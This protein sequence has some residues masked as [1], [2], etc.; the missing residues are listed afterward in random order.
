[1]NKILFQRFVVSPL[2]LLLV[3]F[4]TTS[5]ISAQE[6]EEKIK[7]S[8]DSKM[9]RDY[10]LRMLDEMKSILKENYYDSKMRGIDLESRIDAAK[11]RVKTNAV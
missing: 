2:L 11:T 4:A 9:A 7:L 6:K 5:K 3:V 10:S 8:S 1:M